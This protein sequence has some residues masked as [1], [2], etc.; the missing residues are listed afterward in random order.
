MQQDGTDVTTVIVDDVRFLVRSS[1]HRTFWG[2]VNAGA[3]E[4]HTFRILRH[5]LSPGAPFIDVGAWIGPTA[6]YAASLGASV[7]AFECDPTALEQLRENI[8]VNPDLA[9]RITV[10]PAGLSAED[11]TFTLH[12]ANWG[13]SE[14]TVFPV[15]ERRRVVETLTKTA[16]VE[17]LA[18]RSA[19]EPWLNDPRALVKIDVEGAEYSLLSAL[20]ADVALA[21]CSFYISFHPQNLVSVDS[22]PDRLMRLRETLAWIDQFWSHSWWSFNS[23]TIEPVSKETVLGQSI[24]G[25]PTES[26]LFTRAGEEQVAAPTPCSQ[27]DASMSPSTPSVG[28]FL[29]CEIPVFIPAFNNPTYVS[30]MIRQLR[31]LGL[32]NLI[33]IDNASTTPAMLALLNGKLDA[34]VIRLSVNRGPRHILTHLPTYALL[35]D[36][37]VLSDPDLELNPLMPPD[38]LAHLAAV[39]EEYKVGKAGLALRIDDKD[40]M[41]DDLLV[42]SENPVPVWETEARFWRVQVGEIDKLGPIYL[43]RTDTTFALYNKRYFSPDALFE[44]VRVAGVFTCRHLPWYRN[45][46]MPH[47]EAAGYAAT[48]GRWTN[49]VLPEHFATSTPG[50]LA[51]GD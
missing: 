6:L 10:V 41:R 40:Q 20:G 2:K 22:R 11:G 51:R 7:T 3:W 50:S 47:E 13:N 46:G 44:A 38:F 31:A 34:K 32:E 1:H 12:S 48:A 29:Q 17:G 15:V 43:A 30:S 36:V 19:L 4:P 28:T 35:P 39:T 5:A 42:G 49:Y 16:E 8:E 37:F 21:A 33:V 27:V 24:A 45:N 14:S 9:P 26:I 18:V 25:K 23:D